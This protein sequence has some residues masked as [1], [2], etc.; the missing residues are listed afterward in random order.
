VTNNT[1][2]DGLFKTGKINVALDFLRV[3]ISKGHQLDDVT[4]N[5]LVNGL[6]RIGETEMTL[7]KMRHYMISQGVDP[8]VFRYVG[9]A[10][11]I[12]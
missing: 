2:I 6:Q 11:N 1:L 8:D 7:D 9:C 4:G 5:I 10:R 3:M 12:K